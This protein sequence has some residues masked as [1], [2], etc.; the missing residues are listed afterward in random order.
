MCS[1]DLTAQAP[2][3]TELA[4][5]A[6][7]GWLGAVV[8]PNSTVVSRYFR[9]AKPKQQHG[10]YISGVLADSPAD[11]ASLK[12]MDLLLEVDGVKLTGR[13]ADT[14]AYF[15]SMEA[16][17][18][19]KILYTRFNRQ[20]EEWMESEKS[21]TIERRPQTIAEAPKT[22]DEDFGYECAPFTK[23]LRL[24]TWILDR[25]NGVYLTKV[26]QG[27]I[28][29]VNGVPEKSLIM[30]VNGTAVGDP[31]ALKA[32]LAQFKDQK[33]AVIDILICQPDGYNQPI[34]RKVVVPRD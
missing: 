22:A 32:A 15:A 31:A 33:G 24:S 19:V 6:N 11:K 16:G 18:T 13:Y 9:G 20:V 12:V 29:Y 4:P 8:S 21:I 10:V 25:Y 23:D 14:E 17:K 2:Q 27:S 30:K 7:P 5:S 1:S 26:N 3:G 28:F 34:F